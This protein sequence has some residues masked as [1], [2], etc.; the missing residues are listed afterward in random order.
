MNRWI[1]P[2]DVDRFRAVV[3][4]RFGLSLYGRSQADLAELLAERVGASGRSCDEYLA[5]LAVGGAAAEI[6]ALAAALTVPETYFFRNPEQFHALAGVV[7]PDRMRVRAAARR[8]DVLSMACATG[9]EAYS[10]AMVVHDA[11]TGPG[12]TVSVL[13]VDLNRAALRVAENARYTQWSL[14]AMPPALRRRWL[15]PEGS[16][17]RVAEEIR[18]LVRFTWGNPAV[19]G[20][21]WWPPDGYDVVFCRNVLMYLTPWHAAAVLT[22][23]TD[24]LAPGGFL[25]L[26]HAETR[27]GRRPGLELQQAHDTFYYRRT[28][29]ARVAAE[30]PPATGW[31]ASIGAAHDRIDAL[32]AR[33]ARPVTAS[34]A[35]SDPPALRVPVPALAVPAAPARERVLALM[36]LERFEEALALHEA[37]DP[38]GA[39]DPDAV[40]VHAV[41][42][43]QRGLLD[44]AEDACRRVLDA[45]R[46]DA[47]AQYVLA[48]CRERAGDRPGAMAHAR[49]AAH[50]DPGFAMPRL[51][52]GLLAR[53]GDDAGTARR[54]LGSALTLLAGENPYRL[55]LFGGGLTRSALIDLC[56]RELD[57]VGS[58]A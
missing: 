12:W 24:A 56:R 27:H 33:A 7:V 31:I 51:G 32:A 15:R 36:R 50:L 2:A 1:A 6:D 23:L 19:D 20:A 58:A 53:L 37:S 30:A 41:L 54:E 13:G 10:L 26:G 52:L 5:G 47:G 43:T 25:F 22:R 57:T 9:E 48:M 17:V 28:A 40:L 35:G 3:A 29:P 11:V 18:R 44:R 14:R 42:L 39:G 4:Q 55:L 49:T 21:G 8:L 16:S 45:D 46:R 38:G 34:A